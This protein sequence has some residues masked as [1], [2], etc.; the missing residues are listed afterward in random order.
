VIRQERSELGFKD[1]RSFSV[2]EYR[3]GHSYL[4]IRGFPDMEDDASGGSSLRVV[5]FFFAGASRI[6]SWKD[7]GPFEIR[8]PSEAEARTL[9]ARIG[10]LRAGESLFLLEAGSIESYVVAA[11]VYWAEFEIGAGA[12][13]PL[14]SDDEGYRQAHPP[15][16][17][18]IRF[19]E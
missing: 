6:A 4:V 3:H 1:A 2:V 7:L 5:D 19:A 8:H 9:E 15:V 13:S 11:R 17:D 18:L 16:N 10:A 12:P 14:A